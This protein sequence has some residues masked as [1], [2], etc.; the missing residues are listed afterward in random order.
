MT[1]PDTKTPDAEN[2]LGNAINAIQSANG[3]IY[4]CSS[5]I[6]Q[7]G[8]DVRSIAMKSIDVLL[9]SPSEVDI[10]QRK[11]EVVEQYSTLLTDFSEGMD[12]RVSLLNWS[13]MDVDQSMGLYLLDLGRNKD[14]DP[15]D[16]RQLAN[17]M[18]DSRKVIPET[19]ETIANLAAA[20]RSSAGGLPGLEESIHS[21]TLTL[22]RLSGELDLGDA[23]LKRQIVLAGRL[24]KSL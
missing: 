6:R 2:L 18:T 24:L 20:I 4:S 7:L 21:A 9:S 3:L 19:I 11:R 13:W 1:L 8:V 17:A 5:T 16:V 23:V 22:E 14:V 10:G 12:S 15:S